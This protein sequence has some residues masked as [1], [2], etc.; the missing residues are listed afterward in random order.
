MFSNLR[1]LLML[2]QIQEAYGIPNGQNHHRNSY[3]FIDKY[4]TIQNEET[5]LPDSSETTSHIQR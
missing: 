4:L 5:I 2:I 1:P 3:I